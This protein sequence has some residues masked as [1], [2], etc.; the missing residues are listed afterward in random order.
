MPLAVL[1]GAAL[2]AVAVFFGLRRDRTPPESAPQTVEIK[3]LSRTAIEGSVRAAL[4]AQKP[5]LRE[6]CWD[7]AVKASALPAKAVYQFEIGIDEHGQEIAR[8]IS[9]IEGARSDVSQCL[10]MVVAPI[11]V[12]PTRQRATIRTRVELP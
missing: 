4:E 6:R 5:M 11:T 8:G 12:A 9:E 10:R 3:P 7:P 2:I 1:G